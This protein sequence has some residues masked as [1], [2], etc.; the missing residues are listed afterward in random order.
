LSQEV[1][2]A[3]G[4][5]FEL[6]GIDSFA[7]CWDDGSLDK[8]LQNFT[9]ETWIYPKRKP[10]RYEWWTI[11][12]KPESY[13]LAFIGLNDGLHSQSVKDFGILFRVYS[14]EPGFSTKLVAQKGQKGF[15]ADFRFN[16]WHHVAAIY[17]GGVN[18]LEIYIDGIHVSTGL[19]GIA[20]GP[21]DTP[22]AFYVG[23]ANAREGEFFFGC[24]PE[25]FFFDGCIDELG[26]W[27]KARKISADAEAGFLDADRFTQALWHFDEP[28]GA[29]AFQDA[30]DN[31]NTLF[32]RGGA[33]GLSSI[34]ALASTWANVK[35][36]H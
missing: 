9:I 5:W 10:K 30:S 8:D 27:K 31:G 17:Y 3:G 11:A 22:S 32:G 18:R 33:F 26:I 13:E 7:V 14:S 15:P 1:S 24:K 28:K 20:P 21:P 34:G 29:T 35:S 25:S 4:G 16:E 36:G 12:A 23:G 6:N 2:P 19:S